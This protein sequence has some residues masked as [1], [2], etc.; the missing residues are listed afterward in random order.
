MQ[1]NKEHNITPKTITNEISN[2]LESI[3]E[4]DYVTVDINDDIG[5]TLS[6]SRE[7]DIESL[8]KEMQKLA[9]NLEFEKAAKLRDKLFEYTSGK[10]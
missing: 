8:K 5:I 9:S 2:I 7:E 10:K 4:K 3:Y 6:G 1:Y